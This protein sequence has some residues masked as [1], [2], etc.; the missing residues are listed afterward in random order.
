MFFCI[1]TRIKEQKNVKI[2]QKDIFPQI[3]T[4]SKKKD[5]ITADTIIFFQRNTKKA[6]L[7][8]IFQNYC[9]T[10]ASRKN[11]N[12]KKI[13]RTYNESSRDIRSTEKKI[14]Q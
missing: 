4:K 13:Q 14:P 3:D 5:K 10:F 12:N 6:L 2:E 8:F 11:N 9:T 1:F 7:F